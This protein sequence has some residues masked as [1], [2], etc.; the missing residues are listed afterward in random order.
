MCLAIIAL[1]MLPGL[2]VVVA[3]NRDENHARP[4]AAAD[5]WADDPTIVGGRDLRSGGTWMAMALD[6]RYAL[7]TN[8]RDPRRV[9][10]DAPSR[11]ALVRDFLQ[12]TVAPADYIAMVHGRGARYNGFNLVV[13]DLRETWYYGNRG[14]APRRLDSGVH[15][16][17]N[18][19]LDTPWPKLVRTREAF[20]HVLRQGGGALCVEDLLAALADR[21]V[22]PDDELPDTGV[23]IERERLLSSAFIVNPLYG[24]RSSSV[25]ALGQGSCELHEVRFAPDGTAQGR[26][27]LAY[28]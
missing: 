22:A 20:Q 10:D 14:A 9:I 4:T 27:D 7:V 13:G 17:S 28:S 8:F 15:A 18:H 12:G 19:L 11:G 3:A 23:G 21:T 1:N 25:M 2:P 16:V 26:V 6:G 5:R 24:T